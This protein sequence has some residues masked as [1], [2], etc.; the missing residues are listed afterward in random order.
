MP[1]N[2]F[3]ETGTLTITATNNL[4]EVTPTTFTLSGTT[5]NIELPATYKGIFTVTLTAA[6][7][8]GQT[9]TN[10]FDVTVSV[11]TQTGCEACTGE[12]KT[13]CTKCKSGYSLAAGAC[14]LIPPPAANEAIPST[15]KQDSY[16][17]RDV[18]EVSP[19]GVG[20]SIFGM[21]ALAVGIGFASGSVPV[22]AG[23]GVG[24]C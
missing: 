14:A 16:L 7:Y 12:G 24:Q 13:Q 8:L 22:I 3:S 11:C 21:T 9:V 5:L 17:D 23:L 4:V 19:E 1:A 10:Q 2:T 15:N 18:D 20:A 6:D